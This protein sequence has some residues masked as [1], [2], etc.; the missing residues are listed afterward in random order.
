MTT[1]DEPLARRYEGVASIV[2][3]LRWVY[4]RRR[5]MRLATGS[6]VLG[7]VVMAS[8]TVVGLA[9][10]FWHEQPPA[11][12]R[13]GL[14]AGVVSACLAACGWLLATG[15]LWRQTSAQTARFIEQAMPEL[16]NDFINTVLLARDDGQSSP[17][18]VQAAIAEAARRAQYVDVSRSVRATGVKRAAVAFAVA[19]AML[20][21]LGVLNPTALGRGLLATLQPTSFVPRI[22][23]I[24]L[25][26]M[27][28]VCMGRDHPPDGSFFANEQ[29][30]VV[31]TIRNDDV[32][33]HAGELLIEGEATPRP[34]VA[35]EAHSVYTCPLGA[36]GQSFRYAVRIGTSRWP[37]DRPWYS[38]T[39]VQRVQI[40]GASTRYTYPAYTGLAARDAEG[41]SQLEAPQGSVARLSLKLAS[42]VPVVLVEQASGAALAM[43]PQKDP[44]VYAADVPIDRDGSYRIVIRDSAGRVVQQLPDSD[45]DSSRLDLRSAEGQAAV[46]GAYRIR[47]V[48]DAAPKIDFIAPGRDVAVAPGGRL[49]LR[50]KVWDDYSIE[51]VQLFVARAGQ[52]EK[53]AT[54]LDFAKVARQKSGEVDY[55]L[56]LGPQYAK[57]EVLEYYA[58]V[59]DNRTIGSLGPQTTPSARFK[60]TVQDAAELAAQKA[61]RY[62]ALRQRLL[63]MLK[64]QESQRVSTEVC[65][66][67]ADLAK[68]SA[69]AREIA[70]AQSKLRADMADLV[71][72]FEFDAEMVTIQQAM[73]LLASNEAPL[74]VEQAQALATVTALDLRDKPAAALAGTQD[75]IIDTLQTLLSIMPSLHGKAAAT[76]PAAAGGDLTPEAREK[77]QALKSD[78]EKFIDEQKKIVAATDRLAKKPVDNFQDDKLLKELQLAEDK[79]EK[80][81]NEAFTDFSKLAQQDFSNPTLMKELLSVKSDVTMAKDALAKKATEI[82]TAIEDNGIENAESLTANIEKWLPDKPDREKWAME[83][84][85]G[86][87]A[88]PEAPELPKELE[89]LVGDLLEEEEDLFDQMQDLTSKYNQSGDKGIG[90][91]AAD[92]PISNMNAQGVTGN[93]LPNTSELSGRSGEGREGKSSGEF[94]EDKAEGKGG[95]RTP[96]RLT[97]EPFQQGQ[98][99]D[100]SAEAPGGSTGGGKISGAGA[101]GLEGPVPPELQKEMQRLAGKQASLINKAERMKETFKQADYSGFNKAIT[102]MNRV[103]EDLKANR[104][105]NALRQKDEMLGALRQTQILLTGR[106]EVDADTTTAMPK[107]IRDDISDAMNGNLPAEYKD[108]LQQYYRRLS[109]ASK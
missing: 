2:A 66:K 46:S 44:A 17:E 80:F 65:R 8:L 104:F 60:V 59:T 40:L 70:A 5:A 55:T 88:K 67:A 75:R 50:M 81:L 13:W 99:D 26:G 92:G 62:E 4:S 28:L 34:M 32:A 109:E 69:G 23:D 12:L 18:L 53:P 79:W 97:P 101:K 39:V 78:L 96:T 93:Q 42:A 35:S 29:L 20:A 84:P 47:A 71:A 1:L 100:K 64:V 105:T 87:Q 51:H 77:L 56:E 61:Q 48:P 57:G 3:R 14:L 31:A 85:A 36:V 91:D 72:H 83:D 107:Y 63:A 11:L 94:V 86:G 54:N 30:A 89:D 41:I 7:A 22:N 102:L 27:K 103:E 68:L 24:E 95:R 21:A 90:W 106:I 9:A 37:A 74:A 98:V 6:L 45:G 43:K 25:V 15:V 73:G 58:T 108:V 19:A 49:P 82:A 33:P 76:Q 38:V 10:G 52:D 16:R